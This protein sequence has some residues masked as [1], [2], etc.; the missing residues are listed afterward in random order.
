MMY[1]ANKGPV[2]TAMRIHA[3]TPKNTTSQATYPVR[4]SSDHLLFRSEAASDRHSSELAEAKVVGDHLS[5][6]EPSTL[7]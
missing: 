2:D 7:R 1:N 4:Y 6:G 3:P 5:A